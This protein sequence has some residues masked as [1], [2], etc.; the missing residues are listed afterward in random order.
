[1]RFVFQLFLYLSLLSAFSFVSMYSGYDLWGFHFKEVGMY[2]AWYFAGTV[3]SFAVT[4]TLFKKDLIK[5]IAVLLN[6]TVVFVSSIHVCRYMLEYYPTKS[7]NR[8]IASI[9]C[10]SLMNIAFVLLIKLLV[11][12]INKRGEA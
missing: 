4:Q 1:M 2:A 3:L 5:I 6:V 12:S 11:Y 7:S 9:I 8:F 10:I